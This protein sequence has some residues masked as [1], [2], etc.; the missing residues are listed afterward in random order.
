MKAAHINPFLNSTLKLMENMIG[1]MPMPGQKSL[2]QNFHSHRWDVSGIIGV[3]GNAEGIIAIR[4]TK[5]MVEKLLAASG[6]FFSD[7]DEFNELT[8]SMIGEIANVIAGNALSD[9]SQY[10]LNI[11]VPIVIQGKDHTIAWPHNNPVI[12]IPFSSAFG[13]FEVCV[14][15]KEN[16]VRSFA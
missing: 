6:V 15:L 2:L 11:T 8:N 5:N 7:V 9:I 14:S 13:P 16:L 12:V 3:T 1:R 10:N 4:M